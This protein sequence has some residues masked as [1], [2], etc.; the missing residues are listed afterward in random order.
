MLDSGE[1]LPLPAGEEPGKMLLGVEE[2][3]FADTLFVSAAGS[4][5]GGDGA[6]L[7]EKIRNLIGTGEQDVDL[8]RVIE[9]LH[10]AKNEI[11][12]RTRGKGE[13]NDVRAQL[14][15]A[16]AALLDRTILVSGDV[17]TVMASPQVR[18]TFGL[19]VVGGARA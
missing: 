4:R 12:P 16:R 5:P 10:N 8:T 15:Q 18:E 6:A 17:K 19:D 13:L 1:V 3:V 2:G 7:S 9:R 14:D 11:Q